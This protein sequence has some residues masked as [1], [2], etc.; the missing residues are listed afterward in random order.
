M[1]CAA[2]AFGRPCLLWVMY[3]LR[4]DV[5]MESALPQLAEIISAPLFRCLHA[6]PFRSPGKRNRLLAPVRTGLQAV[7]DWH[8]T[9]PPQTISEP[10]RRRRCAADRIAHCD[11]ASLSD[12]F[13]HHGSSVC[14]WRDDRRC[15]PRCQRTH[16]A[17]ARTA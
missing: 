4:G 7:E 6:L 10:G 17:Y 16:V 5:G 8:E 1:V 12:A 14:C 13:S 11:G 15:C 9:S 3:R 2:K